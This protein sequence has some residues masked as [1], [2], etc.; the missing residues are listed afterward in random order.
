MHASAK[1]EYSWTGENKS[2]CLKTLYWNN[3]NPSFVLEGELCYGPQAYKIKDKWHINHVAAPEPIM[4][5]STVYGRWV[6]EELYINLTRLWDCL[7]EIIEEGELGPVEMVC[8]PKRNRR[9]PNESPVFFVYTACDNK[10]RV[11]LLLAT[12]V[13]KDIRYEL[14]RRSYRQSY[15]KPV[16]NHRIIWDEDEPFTLYH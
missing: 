12:I 5:S 16:Y 8:P 14:S 2:V 4:S 3:G 15:S 6:I 7:K 13:E 10:E 11:G 9:D 1:R